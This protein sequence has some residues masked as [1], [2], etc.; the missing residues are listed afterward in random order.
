MK[1]LIA[2]K[3]TGHMAL[4]SVC[5][6]GLVGVNALAAEQALEILAD[7]PDVVI[8]GTRQVQQNLKIAAQV[9]VITREQIQESGV[10]TVNEAVM[11]LAGVIGSPS[12]FGG[13]EYSLDLGG[14]GDTASSNTVIVVD[15]IPLRE[16]DQSEVRI[17]SIPVENVERI[18]IQRG[19][20]NVLYGEGATA[21]VINIITRASTGRTTDAQSGSVS[22]ALGSF[23]AKELRANVSKSFDALEVNVAGVDTRS[24]GYR[25]HSQSH[26]RSGQLSLK[27]KAEGVRWGMNVSREDMQAKT[28][29]ALTQEEFKANPRQAQALS[30]AN[31]TQMK[32]NLERYGIFAEADVGPVVLR[33]DV[34]RKNRF[35]DAVAVQY[36]SRVPLTFDTSS[37]YLGLSARNVHQWAGVSNQWIVGMDSTHWDQSRLYPTQPS[38]G[39]VLL[40]SK[41]HSF[42]VRNEMDFST[43]GVRVSAG[44]REES[45]KRHQLFAGADSQS[46]E[47]LQAWDLGL[48]KSLSST[49]SVY[50][51]Y[52]KSYRVPNLDEFTTPIYDMNGAAINLLPQTDRTREIGWK[53]MDSAKRSAGVRLY[54]TALRN[55]IV[56]DPLQYGNI[57]LDET[58]RQGADIYA[59]QAVHPQVHV[60]GSLGLRQSTMERGANANKYLPLA[61]RQVASLRAEWTPVAHHKISLGWMYV[62]RQYISGDFANEQSMPSYA[63]LDLRYGYRVGSWDL[64]AVVRNL[65]DKK[66]HS[67]ATT[68]DGYSVYPDP[69]RSVTFMARYRF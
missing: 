24:D 37:N 4:A 49:Q 47:H 69:G 13:S 44:W 3:R 1:N 22:V 55:E 23:G 10:A 8:T 62:G 67:Y 45:F 61:A 51:R 6:S 52:A 32:M 7:N 68:T 21:G 43:Y 17:A 40:D 27:G 11:K 39:T 41:A 12:L 50:V 56:Y 9:M 2:Q 14:F 26:T 36:G 20:A 33:A 18:E 35:Y 5:L 59:Q 31:D 28:A 53:Y 42:Y 38:W 30:L 19:S 66:Y 54:R 65:T 25:D 34:A 58:R 16:A 60:M 15:G 63:L 29:G 46:D 48:S 64:S 57:N